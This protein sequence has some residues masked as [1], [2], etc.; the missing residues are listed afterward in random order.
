MST[1]IKNTL[2]R[3]ATMRAPQLSDDKNKE[4]RFVFRK[5]DVPIGVFDNAV[6]SRNSTTT[7]WS[8]MKTAAVNFAKLDENS[9]KNLDINLYD[10]SIWLARN[11]ASCS[12]TD[13][14]SKVDAVVLVSPQNYFNKL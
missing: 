13:L 4:N 3:F 5:N 2:F 10:F 6:S 11:K 12:E 1:E 7:K 14:Q 9:I 8:A